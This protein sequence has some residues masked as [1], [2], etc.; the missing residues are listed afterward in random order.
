MNSNHQYFVFAL[1]LGVLTFVSGC[2]LGP[3]EGGRSSISGKV[4]LE[5]YNSSNVLV[6]SFYITEERVYIIY[7]DDSIYGDEYRTS[8]DGSYRFDFLRKG[9]YKVF[10]Y[11]ECISCPD[12]TEA[13]FSE[14]EITENGENVVLEDIVIKKW[15]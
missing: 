5:E 14:V 10:A 2:S 7:G 8:Y 4:F 1:M 9:N 11:S 12:F 15:L 13:I 6:N 3:G